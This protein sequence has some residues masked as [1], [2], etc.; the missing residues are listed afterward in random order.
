MQQ[1]QHVQHWRGRERGADC[2]VEPCVC[3]VCW[4]TVPG[5]GRADRLQ[6]GSKLQRRQLPDGRTHRGLQSCVLAVCH[7]YLMFATKSTS[8]RLHVNHW[9]CHVFVGVIPILFLANFDVVFQDRTKH[10]TT[11]FLASLKPLVLQSNSN[12]LDQR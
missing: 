7:R 2:N 4:G 9:S 6:V 3:G 12:L 11:S 10:S 1:R 8:S 5:P